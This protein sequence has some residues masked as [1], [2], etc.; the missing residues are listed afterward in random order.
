[1]GAA[2]A[3]ALVVRVSAVPAS[4]YQCAVLGA[5]WARLFYVAAAAH[6]SAQPQLELPV[7]S[8]VERPLM[9]ACSIACLKSLVQEF[10]KPS[11]STGLSAL[12]A[13]CLD[14]LLSETTL[15]IAYS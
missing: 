3:Q 9:T 7:P 12:G 13:A 15:P 10:S 11:Q 1:M 2:L 8:G 6:G 4:E 14:H 5:G